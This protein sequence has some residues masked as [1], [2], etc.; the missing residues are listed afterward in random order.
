MK[1]A[2][3]LRRALCAV[4]VVIIMTLPAALAASGVYYVNI[5]TVRVRTGPSDSYSI[6][7]KLHKGDVVSYK[8]SSNGWYYVRY[9]NG[10]YGWIYRK[11]LTSVKTSSSGSSG[12]YKAIA[13][14]NMRNKASL[15]NSYVVGQVK[16][17]AKVTIKKQSHGYAYVTYKGKS[18]W[19]VA[20]YLKKV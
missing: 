16:K 7:A 1:S 11:Y 18:G 5:D 6:K 20:K 13:T 14:L 3:T 15:N 9:K 2:R 4:L 10:G 19:V 8:K 12:T 17:G